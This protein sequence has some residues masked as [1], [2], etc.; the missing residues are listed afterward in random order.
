MDSTSVQKELA[1]T[2]LTAHLG[3]LKLQGNQISASVGG[4]SI[5]FRQETV[6]MEMFKRFIG[7]FTSKDVYIVNK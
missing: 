5:S 2:F 7:T 4:Q 3:E 1:S 6:W